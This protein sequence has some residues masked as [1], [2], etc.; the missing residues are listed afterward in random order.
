MK[1]K[2]NN[3]KE[4]RTSTPVA[5]AERPQLQQKPENPDTQPEICFTGDSK[6]DI[7]QSAVYNAVKASLSMVGQEKLLNEQNQE[8]FNQARKALQ[9]LGHFSYNIGFAGEQS[10]GKSTVINSL[11]R[12]PL[13][14]TCQLTTT[15]V[16][17]QLAYSDHLRVRAVDD[18]SQ[19]VVLDFDCVMPQNSAAQRQFRD[20]FS[21]LLE[22]SMEA[23]KIMVI[24][25]FQ[26]FTDL[27]VKN[28]YV[29][30]SDIDISPENPRHVMLLLFVLLAV[31]VGQNDDSWK[32][33]TEQLMKKRNALLRMLGIPADTVNVSVFAQADF[34]LLRSGLVIT[35][36]PGLGSNAGNQVI[37]GRTVKGHNEITKEAI[38]N[39]DAMVFLGTP[40]NRKSGYEVL[41]EMLSS[42][43]LKQTVYKGDRIITVL[44]QADRCGERERET[45][46][47]NFCTALASV[48]VD[49]KP[50]DI[51][52]YSAIA[53]EHMFEDIPVER[54]LLYK[55]EVNEEDIRNK[56]ARKGKRFEDLIEEKI[57]DLQWEATEAYKKSGIEELLSTFR[58]TYVEQGKYIKSTAA[59]Q[60]V[61]ALVKVSVT[62]L[63][64]TA[65]NCELICR[66]HGN[67]KT[68]M[69]EKVKVA[70]E[71]PIA[72]SI[73]RSTKD[74][75]RIGSD[76][77]TELE[78]YTDNVAELYI[79]AFCEGLAKYQSKLKDI[80]SGFELTWFGLG[81]K[82]RI[83]V[84]GSPNRQKY[85]N[86]LDEMNSF[87]I[88]LTKVNDKYEKALHLVRTK[89]DRF[90]EDTL[91]GL[92]YLEQETQRSLD[93]VIRQ[94]E[95]EKLSD[96]EIATLRT[97]KEQMVSFVE[98]QFDVV[99]SQVDRQR[100]AET[101]AMNKIIAAIFQ[102]NNT[103]LGQFVS[104]T[105]GE[106]N[107]RLS[108]GGFFTNKE[109]IL[110][111]GSDGLKAA[112]NGLALTAQEKDNI[113]A[114]IDAG[115]TAILQNEVPLWIDDLYGVIAIY[116]D[117]QVQVQTPLQ[118]MINSMGQN[119]EENAAK[120]AAMRKKVDCWKEVAK[121]LNEK[122]CSTMTEACTYV[123]DREPS[124]IRMQENICFDCFS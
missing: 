117:L 74:I 87:S 10:S 121:A 28:D 12:Y 69:V 95:L 83:D 35:D 22:Y 71:N 41:T 80:I 122:V 19:K 89:I 44:N 16:A 24:E 60:A 31:Y 103:M 55:R 73:G 94:A 92:K 11:L 9:E 110:I 29:S 34:E 70:V 105:K 5:V 27:D 68:E 3:G 81:S 78:N 39:T 15:A 47:Q 20:R 118:D 17:V 96:E 62:A 33:N 38:K 51:L 101:E 72:D 99:E 104:A 37:N 84:A 65:N 25:N 46:L 58:T 54:T 120:A 67:L 113:T 45:A 109:F 40:E 61:R 14:P 36:L 66:A 30:P 7:L 79:K 4:K 32:E 59:L 8:S 21:K 6:I 1:I 115:V 76:T 77:N 102:L 63:E 90:Y 26:Y 43:K 107:K 85:L 97:L 88:S 98:K 48:G 57:D 82:A 50:T 42:A 86:L 2:G 13:M 119:A 52:P 106:M 18:D 91:D 56:A 111:D 108:Q 93:N 49:K 114:N 53:G 100:D 112:I 124:N 75:I 23:M 123:N 116:E 64:Q